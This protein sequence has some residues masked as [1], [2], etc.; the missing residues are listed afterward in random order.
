[1]LREINKGCKDPLVTAVIRTYNRA[2]LVGRAI[3]SVLS[4][5]FKDF[6]LIILDD[7]S[8]DNTS[9]VVRDYMSKDDRISYIRHKK[10]MGTGKGF[11]TANSAA[12]G[13]YVSYLDD[14]DTWRAEKL[15]KQVE[16]FESCSERV[17]LLTGGIQYW[18]SDT[19]NKLRIWIP[20]MKGNIYWEALGTSGDIF[21]PPSVVMI[22]KS[23]LEDVGLFREDMPRGCC[24]Q[25]FRRVAK[26]YEI[27]YITDIVLDYYLHWNAITSIVTKKDIWKY[28]VSHQIKI[29]SIKEDLE[30]IPG[31]Y[32]QELIKLGHHHCL[33]EQW[34][35]GQLSFRKAVQVNGYSIALFAHILGSLTR[36]KSIYKTFNRVSGIAGRLLK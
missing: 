30:K 29:E 21:G 9:E 16:K 25:Y 1:M 6:E 31:V 3:E 33:Y 13:K 15:E 19:G 28:I 4:Q 17:G 36:Q 20:D 22:R 26:K 12:T 10:N 18:N 8:Q 27:D 5:T 34:E 7:Y 24:Q 35:E 2:A 11:N 32:A 23:V 14:D